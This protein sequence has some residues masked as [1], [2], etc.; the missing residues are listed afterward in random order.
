M[1]KINCFRCKHY[2]V[3]WDPKNPK[4]CDFFGFKSS[5]MPSLTVFQSAGEECAAFEPKPEKKGNKKSGNL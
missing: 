3:T 4:G 2:I 5:K 1:T